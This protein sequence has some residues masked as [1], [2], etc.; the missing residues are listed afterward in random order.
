MKNVIIALVVLTAISAVFIVE[1]W[2]W[3]ECRK[4]GHG[5]FY[6]LVTSK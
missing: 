2:R 4:V 6:C 5:V 3:N 1:R